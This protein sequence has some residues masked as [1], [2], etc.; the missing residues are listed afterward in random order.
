MKKLSYLL[1]LVLAFTMTACSEGGGSD[2]P[3]ST[4]E[5]QK[6]EAPS[7]ENEGTP[8]D[9]AENT[10][11]DDDWDDDDWEIDPFDPAVS[12]E[13]NSE[14]EYQ[15]YLSGVDRGSEVLSKEEL[16]SFISENYEKAYNLASFCRGYGPDTLDIGVN[17]DSTESITADD[18]ASYEYAPTALSSKEEFWASVSEYFS[19]ATVEQLKKET[20]N[21]LLYEKDGVLYVAIGAKGGNYSY[22]KDTVEIVQQAEDRV[23]LSIVKSYFIEGKKTITLRDLVK[24]DGKWKFDFII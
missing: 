16:D 2:T 14:D 6:S 22:E 11:D 12:V 23:T 24:E 10:G 5:A 18:G 1:A 4:P 21:Y 17:Y 13:F 3:K 7:D 15:Q 8:T 9:S 20:A 19:A